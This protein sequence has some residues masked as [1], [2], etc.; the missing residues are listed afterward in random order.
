MASMRS[1]IRSPQMAEG[2]TIEDDGKRWTM[3]LRDGLTFHD[4]SKV[5]AR[6]CVASLRRWMKRDALGQTVADRLDALEAPD[7]R[8]LVFRLK[9]PFAAL[10]FALAKPQPSPPLIMPER[11]ATTDPFKQIT[12]VVGSGPFRFVKEEYVS[13]SLVG[14]AKYDAYKPRDEAPS[15]TTGAKR[16]LVDRDRVARHPRPVD[17]HER[18]GG[19]RG[20][21]ARNPAARSDPAAQARARRRGRPARS[22]RSVSRD[23]PESPAGPDRQPR[24]AASDAGGGQPGRGDAV[25]H[26]RRRE[27]LQRADRLLPSGD[28]IRRTRPAWIASAAPRALPNCRRW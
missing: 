12:E 4:G 17:R 25:L 24:A 11:I 9:K 27:H 10:P 13:G 22:V 23:A 21:L 1:S 6:D 5:L 14:F 15:F 18:A 7:D 20:R 8:T 26:G 28:G 19:R 16:A 3:T 2:H